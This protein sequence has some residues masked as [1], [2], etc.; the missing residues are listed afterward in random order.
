MPFT[1]PRCRMT[2]HH[3]KDVQH[4]Y[5]GNCH[6]YTLAAAIL[7]IN[8]EAVQ[9]GKLP[10]WTIFNKPADYPAGYIARCFEYDQPTQHAMTGELETLRDC[11]SQCGL[12]CLMRGEQDHPCVVETWT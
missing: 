5:C 11:L 1:C 9:R 6:D 3:P 7:D 4:G 12:V 10:M 8:Q 2:S